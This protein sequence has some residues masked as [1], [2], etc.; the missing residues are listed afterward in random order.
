[1][2]SSHLLH[3][4]ITEPTIKA[5]YDVYNTLGSGFLEK[6]YENAL[7]HV[8]RSRAFNVAQQV[9]IKVFFEGALVGEYFADLLVNDCVIV[10]VK[11][12]QS[13]HD[14]HEAQLLNYLK[15]SPVE[16]GLLLN[17]GESPEFRRK[18]FTNDRKP[19]LLPGSVGWL[20]NPSLSV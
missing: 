19:A 13:I 17:F 14:A 11:A 18:L 20:P 10:E 4:E 5:F 6:V 9:P 1:M 15:E 8:L 16:V 2:N 7:A 3:S 12:C